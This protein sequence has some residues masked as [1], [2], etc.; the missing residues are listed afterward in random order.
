MELNTAA[1]CM[2][3]HLVDA[4]RVQWMAARQPPPSQPHAA[5][6]AV[7]HDR[8]PGILR[9]TRVEAAGGGEKRADCQL[10]AAY[11]HAKQRLHQ[12][13]PRKRCSTSPSASAMSSAASLVRS[14]TTTSTGPSPAASRRKCSLVTRLIRFRC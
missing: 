4:A 3:G 12:A 11:Q 8:L 10:V 2:S 13:S 9:A 7:L 14:L 5:H 1:T 6:D